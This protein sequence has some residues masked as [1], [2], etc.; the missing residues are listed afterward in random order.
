[1]TLAFGRSAGSDPVLGLPTDPLLASLRRWFPPIVSGY[2]ACSATVDAANLRILEALEPPVPMHFAEE[3]PL[4][5]VVKLIKSATRG[6]FSGG[7][8][9]IR[10]AN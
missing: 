8:C 4:E 7:N 2:S 6:S 10:P 5:D 3:T 9:L 1:M